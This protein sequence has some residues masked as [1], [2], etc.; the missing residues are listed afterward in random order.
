MIKPTWPVMFRSIISN[1]IKLTFTLKMGRLLFYS[2]VV[3]SILC[4]WYCLLLSSVWF[5]NNLIFSL[6]SPCVLLICLYYCGFGY[7]CECFFLSWYSFRAST[8]LILFLEFGTFL[9]YLFLVIILLSFSIHLKKL[10]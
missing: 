4:I 1:F 10:S 8:I 7:N 5:S 2:L 6:L 9:L 3:P